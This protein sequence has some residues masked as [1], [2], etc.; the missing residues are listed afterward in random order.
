MKFWIENVSNNAETCRHKM[1]EK[2]FY[3]MYNV[4]KTKP[5]NGNFGNCKPGFPLSEVENV[6]KMVY[7]YR[8]RRFPQRIESR[9]RI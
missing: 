8:R 3:S 7:R 6:S 2:T 1:V 4:I 5:I 9:N